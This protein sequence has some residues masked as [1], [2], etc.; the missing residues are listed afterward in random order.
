MRAKDLLKL[1]VDRRV[2]EK[3]DGTNWELKR[4]MQN[5]DLND[6]LDLMADMSQVKYKTAENSEDKKKWSE[7]ARLIREL[8]SKL[9][10]KEWDWYRHSA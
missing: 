8:I 9:Q 7:N 6:I 1:V 3:S 2:E 4:A 10:I 5:V